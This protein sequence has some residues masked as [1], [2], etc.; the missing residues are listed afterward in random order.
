MRL[1]PCTLALA[2]GCVTLIA[3]DEKNKTA[4][5]L[6]DAATLFSE[7]MSTPDR[8]IPQELLEKAA[9]IV[10]VP[11]LNDAAFGIGVSISLTRRGRRMIRV[12]ICSTSG[13]PE[14][15]RATIS[16]CNPLSLASVSPMEG[17]V[18]PGGAN[19]KTGKFCSTSAMGPCRKSAEEK[20][21]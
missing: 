11:G 1:I 17:H 19:A 13:F 5:R 21:S 14:S 16:A 10:L 3:A 15:V 20:R 18:L 2:M 4:E 12:A 7:A 8:S 6:D 9:C